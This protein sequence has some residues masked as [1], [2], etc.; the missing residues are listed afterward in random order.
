[1]R[2]LL[3]TSMILMYGFLS[4]SQE[5]ITTYQIGE[6]GFDTTTSIINL[7]NGGFAICGKADGSFGANINFDPAGPKP[8]YSG[9]LYGWYFIAKYF[10][11]GKLD[12]VLIPDQF[13]GG[14]WKNHSLNIQKSST[15]ATTDNSYFDIAENSQGELVAVG[16]NSSWQAFDFDLSN[17]GNSIL[18]PFN[19]FAYVGSLVKYGSNYVP[20]VLGFLQGGSGESSFLGVEVDD[21]DNI[22]TGGYYEGVNTNFELSGGNLSPTNST[23]GSSGGAFVAKYNNTGVADW[24]LGIGNIGDRVTDVAVNSN[25]E[26]IA[27]GVFNANAQFNSLGGG[28]AIMNSNGASDGFVAKYD[29]NGNVVWWFQIGGPGEDYVNSLVVDNNN[30]IYITGSFSGTVNFGGSSLTSN[31]AKDIFIAKYNDVGNLLWIKAYGSSLDD[32]CYDVN[33]GNNRLLLSGNI[34]GSTNIEGQILNASNQDGIFLFLNLDGTFDHVYHDNKV[35]PNLATGAIFNSSSGRYYQIG[36][37]TEGDDVLETL[38]VNATLS[39]FCQPPTVTHAPSVNSCELGSPEAINAGIPAGGQYSGVGIIGNEFYPLI[40]GEGSFDLTYTYTDNDGCFASVP[41]IMTV[42]PKPDVQMSLLD[43][44][45]IN[46]PSFELTN[47][48]PSSGV[49]SGIGINLNE[50]NPSAAGVGYHQVNYTYTDAIGCSGSISEIIQVTDIP[51][52]TSMVTD[53]N[54]GQSDGAVN[55]NVINGQ[56]PFNFYWNSG[57]ITSSLNNVEVGSYT[58]TLTDDNGCT[59]TETAN[60][61]NLNGPSI[62]IDLVNNPSCFGESDGQIQISISGGYNSILWNN[63]DTSLN[64]IG[65]LAGIYEVTVSDTSGCDVYATVELENPDMIIA[66]QN[67]TSASCGLQDGMIELNTTGGLSPY[68]YLWHSTGNAGSIESNLGVGVYTVAITD[69]NGCIVDYTISMNEDGGPTINI[70]NIVDAYCGGTGDVIISTDAVNPTYNWFDVSNNM[71]STSQNLINQISG[72]YSVVVQEN[73]CSSALS[74]TIGNATLEVPEIC[75]VT[76]DTATGTNLIVWD[77]TLTTTFDYF[78]IYR[79]GSVFGNFVLIDSLPYDSL[80]QHTDIVANPQIRSWR[81]KISGVN[82]CG[83]ESDLSSHHKTIHLSQGIGINGEVNLSWDHY[84][85][86]AFGTYDI[87][88]YSEIDGWNLIASIPN[89]I[90]SYTDLFPPAG[91]LNINYILEAAPSSTCVSAR[92]NHNQSR[93]NKT[94]PIAGPSNNGVGMNEFD[95]LNIALYPNPANDVLNV[96]NESGNQVQFSLFTI[97]GKLLDMQLLPLGSKQIDV[98]SLAVGSYFIQ[99]SLK[100]KAITKKL[101]ITH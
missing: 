38:H 8:A 29:P 25:N 50:F 88:R 3:I 65:L 81:Y 19:E 43:P 39:P 77:K 46:K 5:Q 30:D 67:V 99:L 7:A 90:T 82:S 78:K 35:E 66:N 61:S 24:V 101:S 80:S 71:V 75:L 20:N 41:L 42:H 54:C 15:A 11:N 26:T 93:S 85:G 94:Q 9:N 31:G 28:G 2:K 70:D 76:V 79:E 73:G 63:G 62:S 96:V 45:C 86:F 98:S 18:D 16:M 1:M 100:D 21:S 27:V 52:I 48:V 33:I 17:P 47:G 12:T 37:I 14:G 60:V 87:Y 69:Q 32:Y 44:V 97:E 34:K 68:T 13:F 64:P 49:Y 74:A 95:E 23:A 53:A 72:D 40:T 58:L 56:P 84:E 36:S 4:R 83:V 10:A 51:S 89:N 59:T 22:L 6:E 57:Q 91:A 92:A 55:I